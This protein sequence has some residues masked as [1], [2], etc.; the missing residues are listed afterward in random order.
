VRRRVPAT[1]PL[2]LAVIITLIV[3]VPAL[4]PQTG[5]PSGSDLLLHGLAGGLLASTYLLV[6]QS[7]EEHSPRRLL[8]IALL[9]AV[10]VGGVVEVLQAFVPGRQPALTDAVAHGAG[11]TF[12]VLGWKVLAGRR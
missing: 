3:V 1:K 11:A 5:A 10:A 9:A 6:G 7:I 4:W 2:A 12:A 8:P